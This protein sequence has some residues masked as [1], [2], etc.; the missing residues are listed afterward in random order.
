MP[1]VRANKIF[2]P[3]LQFRVTSK[4]LNPASTLFNKDTFSIFVTFAPLI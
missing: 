2:V 3:Y 4:P 1:Q